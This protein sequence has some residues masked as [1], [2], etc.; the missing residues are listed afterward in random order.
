MYADSKAMT[1]TSARGAIA[2][3]GWAP[4]AGGLQQK[5]LSGFMPLRVTQTK[6]MDSP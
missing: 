5:K 6:G 2:M 3:F 4:F 1:V